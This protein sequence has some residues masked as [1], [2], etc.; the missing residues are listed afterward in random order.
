MPTSC[1][2]VRHSHRLVASMKW[3]LVRITQVCVAT[4][5]AVDVL[6][7]RPDP[8]AAITSRCTASGLSRAIPD[9][10]AIVYSYSTTGFATLLR[11]SW[12]RAAT[13]DG[14]R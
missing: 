3:Q 12:R 9:K 13:A 11:L 4:R 10:P 7:R 5:W 14:N 8:G 1:T 6:G 2:G